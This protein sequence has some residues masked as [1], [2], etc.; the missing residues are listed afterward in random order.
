M[1]IYDL[2]PLYWHYRKHKMEEVKWALHINKRAWFDS[3]F[4]L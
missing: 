4:R 1:L 3:K 2:V